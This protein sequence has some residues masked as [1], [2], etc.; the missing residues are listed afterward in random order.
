MKGK[1]RIKKSED[2]SVFAVKTVKFAD[3]AGVDTI[4]RRREEAK[5][6]RAERAKARKEAKKKEKS[7]AAANRLKR[8]GKNSGAAGQQG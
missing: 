8:K 7:E 1:I 2:G 5:K 3:E 4:I 6:K